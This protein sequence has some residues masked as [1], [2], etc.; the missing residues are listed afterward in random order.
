VK[1]NVSNVKCGNVNRYKCPVCG[2]LSSR[3]QGCGDGGVGGAAAE[4]GRM[5]CT[6]VIS[7]LLVLSLVSSK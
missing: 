1:Y 6:L 2:S 7:F 3:N 4:Q 5:N